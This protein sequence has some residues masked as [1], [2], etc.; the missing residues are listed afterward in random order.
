M[1]PQQLCELPL[2]PPDDPVLILHTSRCRYSSEL[3]KEIE[4]MPKKC[5]IIADLSQFSDDELEQ[6]K[7]LPGVPCLVYETKLYLGV[8]AFTKVRDILRS[9]MF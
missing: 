6:I 2:S 5:C 7:W 8:D 9:R 1:N 4:R 3:N